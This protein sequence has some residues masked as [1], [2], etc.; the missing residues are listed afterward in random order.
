[1]NESSF[2]MNDTFDN[3]TFNETKIEEKK[4]KNQILKEA[5]KQIKNLNKK[6]IGKHNLKVSINCSINE[7]YSPVATARDIGD[8]KKNK[9]KYDADCNLY[10]GPKKKKIHKEY[11]K[12]PLKVTQEK[13]NLLDINLHSKK[14]RSRKVE[15]MF[16]WQVDCLY[17]KKILNE[18][19]N[20]IYSAPTS[21][22][23]TLVAEILGLKT[24]FERNKK[25]C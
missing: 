17:N 5:Q 9:I 2:S 3:F 23:K 20:L 7:K 15:R 21:A 24:I 14:Y 10:T 4:Q 22:G 8:K 11:Q 12:D 25:I 18:L 6:E 19:R 16:Q 1:M 13:D